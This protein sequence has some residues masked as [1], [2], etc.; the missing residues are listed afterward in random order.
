MQ[1]L[2]IILGILL[3]TGFVSSGAMKLMKK[4]MAI[5]VKDKFNLPANTFNLIGIAEVLGGI[6]LLV[7]LFNNMEW[8][9]FFAAVGLIILMVGALWY[10]S[11]VKDEIK[12]YIPALA[13]IILTIVYLIVLANG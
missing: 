6:G 3:A 8:I 9:G 2:A 5:A 11:K 12:E 1:T 4:P 13:L 7:G 10:H